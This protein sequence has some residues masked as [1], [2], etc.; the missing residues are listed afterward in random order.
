VSHG[1]S[2]VAPRHRR[3]AVMERG[4]CVAATMTRP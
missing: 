1:S 4:A 2:A 3:G